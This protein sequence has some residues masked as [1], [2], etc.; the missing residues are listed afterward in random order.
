MNEISS[1]AGPAGTG[2]AGLTTSRSVGSSS[3]NADA[4]PLTEHAAMSSSMA[5][6]AIRATGSVHVE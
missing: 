5:F 1:V 3:V 4:M 6:S 2:A